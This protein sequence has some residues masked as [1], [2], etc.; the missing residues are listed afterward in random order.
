MS[1]YQITNSSLKVA[2]HEDSIASQI[3]QCSFQNVESC[4]TTPFLWDESAG[5]IFQHHSVP[6]LVALSSNFVFSSRFKYVYSS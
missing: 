5:W 2:P 1:H 6:C 3:L 4:F